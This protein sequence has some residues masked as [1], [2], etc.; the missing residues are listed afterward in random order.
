MNGLLGFTAKCWA[1]L[2]DA[3]MVLRP[4]RFSVLVVVA[5]AALLASAQGREVTIGVSADSARW[6]TVAAFHACVFLWAFQSWY[7]ARVTLDFAFGQDRGARLDHPRSALIHCYVEFAPRIIAALTYVVAIIACAGYWK[8]MAALVIALVAFFAFLVYRRDIAR[9]LADGEGTRRHSVLIKRGENTG[10]LRSQ[11]LLSRAVMGATLIAYPALFIWVCLD[12]VGFAW[13]LG[14]AAVPFL[15]FSILAAVGSMLVL[16]AREGGVQRLGLETPRG[17]APGYPVVRTLLLVAIGWS[18]LPPLDNHKIRALPQPPRAAKA[19]DAFLTEW[20]AQAPAAADGRKNFIVV[21]AAGG[22]LRAAYW[23]STVLGATQDRA[24]EF[25]RQL[26]AISGV[27]GGSLGGLVFVSLLAQ[28]KAPDTRAKCVRGPMPRDAYECAGQ[29]VLAQDF[30]A[31]TMAALLFPDL[32]QRF[33]P[34]PFP[35]RA[36][37]LE[38]SW[39]RSWAAAGFAGDPWGTRGF[40]S[41]WDGKRHLPALLLN[42]THVE[43]GKRV[44]TSHL[45]VA[46]RPDAFLNAYDFYKFTDNEIRPSTAAHNSARFTYVSPASTLKDG[47]HLVDGGYFENFGAVT[48][49][50]LIDAALWK[51]S[52]DIRPIAIIISNDPELRTEDFPAKLAKYPP[53]PKPKLAWAG[54]VLSPLRAMLHTRD[55]RGLLAAADL[56]ATA[57]YYR[58]DYFQFRLCKD[59]RQPT[60]DDP[61]LGWVLSDESEELMR[62]QLARD[63]GNPEE[64]G[65]LLQLLG[66]KVTP[67]SR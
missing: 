11:P 49:R 16:L 64:M 53:E 32:L 28:D 3:G 44:I 4:C 65:R 51:F 13:L 20:Y 12:A 62:Y 29:M 57:E 54:E 31:P 58:G 37:A 23:T 67:A 7:W 33:V 43:T 35:D 6:W 48:A 22:G 19:L 56:R 18:F 2:R 5:G 42:G 30:L 38:E 59:T 60:R 45:D 8:N 52:T 47:T 17:I 63:C 26:V 61:A 34:L 50:E 40:R 36:R 15:G 9:W 46:G 21:A 55:A 14:S 66:A 24:P 39:E 27:S 41:L 25:R 1:F 10:Q